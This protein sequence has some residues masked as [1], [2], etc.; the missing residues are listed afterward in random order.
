[1]RTHWIKVCAMVMAII[2]FV[3]PIEVKAQE[4]VIDRESVS[5]NSDVEG[6]VSEVSADKITSNEEYYFDLAEEETAERTGE[7]T[8]ENVVNIDG[9]VD[10]DNTSIEDSIEKVEDEP[11]TET[12]TVTVTAESTTPE[13]WY[14]NFDY[15]IDDENEQ[16]ILV[17][18]KGGVEGELTISEQT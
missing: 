5:E 7:K 4:T 8:S 12:V 11:D 2:L 15:T 17:Q 9:S 14:E 13:N 6:E 1:M 18:I 10:R 3:E 16:L